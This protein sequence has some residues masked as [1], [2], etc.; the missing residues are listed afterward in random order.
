[1]IVTDGSFD[2]GMSPIVQVAI[3]IAGILTTF[4]CLV[5]FFLGCVNL[6][7]ADTQ[8][9]KNERKNK[10]LWDEDKEEQN[11]A[12]KQLENGRGYQHQRDQS[13]MMG[14]V[15]QGPDFS[16]SQDDLQMP[17]LQDE[18]SESFKME[19]YATQDKIQE[20]T[21]QRRISHEKLRRNARQQE[22]E[23]TEVKE[24]Q[25]EDDIEIE[26]DDI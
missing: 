10:Y 22:I 24:Q 18:D 13:A 6:Q 8:R 12:E 19:D 11:S 20:N 23:M 25:Q 7:K 2:T 5:F 1:M 26:L 9:R 16:R 15:G 3:S 21:P 14:L 17:G 4:G